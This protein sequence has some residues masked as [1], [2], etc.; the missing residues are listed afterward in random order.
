MSSC[1]RPGVREIRASARRPVN[2]LTRLDLPTLER[3]AKATSTPSR[4]GRTPSEPAAATNRHSAANSLRPA[5]ISAAVNSGAARS[6]SRG[7][8]SRMHPRAHGAS[9]SVPSP[10]GRAAR[11]AR[12]AGRMIGTPPRSLSGSPIS[13]E[14]EVKGAAIQL[15]GF[16]LANKDLRLSNSSILAPFLCMMIDCWI[17]DNRLFH[18]Q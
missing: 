3:P 12:G 8:G 15:C 13:A 7:G 4:T 6:G 14:G 9:S 16:R 18:A 17:T 2:A 10:A 11:E 1:V 5:S